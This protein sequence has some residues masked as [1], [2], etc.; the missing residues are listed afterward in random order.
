M[1][2]LVSVSGHVKARS[3]GALARTNRRAGW[4]SRARDA[5]DLVLTL[6][7]YIPTGP[8]KLIRRLR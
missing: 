8:H 3:K 1:G 4:T 5:R 6:R 2:G 7:V